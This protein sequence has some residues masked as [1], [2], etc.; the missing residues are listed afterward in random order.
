[1]TRQETQQLRGLAISLI[2]IHNF[3]HLLPGA[4][5]ENEYIW[6]IGPILQYCRYIL[7][8]GPHLILNLFSHYGFYGIALFVFLSGYGLASK[9]DQQESLSPVHFLVR[10][11]TKL[12]RLLFVGI[13][14]YYIA[15]RFMGGAEPSWDHIVKLSIFV[16][17]LLPHRTLIFGPWWWF[18]LIMQFY[19]VYI[20]FFY[21]RSLNTIGIF[22]ALCLILQYAITFYCRHDLTNEHGSL[23]FLHYNFPA[24]VLPFS[25]GV[26][27]SRR[28]PS[29]LNSLC[30][31]FVSIIIVIM[32]SFNVWI[33]CIS[34]A[35]AC[36]TLIQ[37][38]HLLC[39]THWICAI[40]S[41][42]GTVSAWAFVIHPIVRRYV[43]QLNNTH[44][45]YLTLALYLAITL[46]IS[47][48]LYILFAYID[49]KPQSTTK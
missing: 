46:S 36:I 28:K 34:G 4:I 10:H 24:L 22:T 19:V 39:R 25:L 41:W 42:L 47:Y 17:N 37:L 29:W 14:L 48:L 8:G 45:V 16:A 7:H 40:L 32:G 1:M 30:L 18:S 20:V 6:S 21:K 44:S 26:F 33:W 27:V 3:C 11:A 35:F 13:L 12:W 43:F 15:F 49:R 31:L 9:Y 23:V 2:I 5:A 38:G